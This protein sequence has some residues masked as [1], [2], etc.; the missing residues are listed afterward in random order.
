MPLAT[1]QL[2]HQVSDIRPHSHHSFEM[3][4][5]VGAMTNMVYI[6]TAPDMPTL[7]LRLYGDGSEMFFKRET[8]I[9]IFEFLSECGLG[10]RML[11]TFVGGRFEEFLDADVLTAEQMRSQ[12][13]SRAIARA[14]ARLHAVAVT[15]RDR[16]P[17]LPG[18]SP[19]KSSLTA[20]LLTWRGKAMQLTDQWTAAGKSTGR[21]DAQKLF[22]EVMML[23]DILE[24]QPTN[25]VFCHNDVR[26]LALFLSL[27][28]SLSLSLSGVA[29]A[30]ALPPLYTDSSLSLSLAGLD[31]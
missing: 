17:Q 30:N 7:L 13:T 19:D 1:V 18:Q 14:M 11:G 24:R 23:A 3:E 2:L 22:D 12:A 6:C 8:E 20:R 25:V 26:S 16:M 31:C 10:P 21:I 29:C 5:L 15:A 9:A 28:V 27:S 4:R